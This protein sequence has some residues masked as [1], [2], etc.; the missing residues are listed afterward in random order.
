MK[1]KHLDRYNELAKLISDIRS[2]SAPIRA[3]RDELLQK[4]HALE[5][6]EKNLIDLYLEVEKD[7]YELV[8]EQAELTPFVSSALIHQ[9][10]PASTVELVEKKPWYKFW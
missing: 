6:E 9:P 10:V 3:K 8:Q 2:R 7:L 5:A 4:I 1:Q